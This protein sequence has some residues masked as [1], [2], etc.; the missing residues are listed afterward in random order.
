MKR[1]KVHLLFGQ[2]LSQDKDGTWK[3]WGRDGLGVYAIE[4]SFTQVRPLKPH[5]GHPEKQSYIVKE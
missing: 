2:H 5:P 4:V 3:V 1:P